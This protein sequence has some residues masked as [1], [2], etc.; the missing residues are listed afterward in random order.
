LENFLRILQNEEQQY[1]WQIRQRFNVYRQCLNR[2]LIARGCTITPVDE[3][4]SIVDSD[5][6]PTKSQS[7]P[8]DQQQ[9]WTVVADAAVA[10]QRL[11][12]EASS[13]GSTI[14]GNRKSLTIKSK[15]NATDKVN[16]RQGTL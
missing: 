16:W 15:R 4:R 7:K 2:E 5:D 8:D 14:V 1:L 11:I 9:Q 13:N 6:L 12:D 10:Y 3:N